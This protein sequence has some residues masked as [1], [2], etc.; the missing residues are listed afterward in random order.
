MVS[1]GSLLIL[2]GYDG[3]DLNPQALIPGI[4]LILGALVLSL[5][6]AF[7]SWGDRPRATG[8]AWT[9]PATVLFYAVC[10]AAALV[11]GGEYVVA[12]VLAAAIPLTAATLITATARAKTV[13]GDDAPCDATAEEHADPFP[14]IA[15]DDATPLGDTSELSGAERTGKP[16]RHTERR[17]R[18][19]SGG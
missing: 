19:R 16:D 2:V 10:A 13:A 6:L 8:I 9:I 14:G 4:A 5:V 1:V 11:A 15:I 7:G 3:A 12:A 18:S 17:G